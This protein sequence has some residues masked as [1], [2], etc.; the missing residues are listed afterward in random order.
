MSKISARFLL[1]LLIL[2]LFAFSSSMFVACSDDDDDNDDDSSGLVMPLNI[3]NSWTYTLTQSPMGSGEYTMV[4][5][6][7]ETFDCGEVARI[8]YS[9]TTYTEGY[10]VWVRNE[11]D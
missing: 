4:V 1:L 2:A 11:E 10:Y 8:N 3:G 6:S 5:G 7:I 9:G